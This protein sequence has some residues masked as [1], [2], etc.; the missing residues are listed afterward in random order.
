M[1]TSYKA[2]NFQFSLA[3]L[4][5]LCL[6]YS[7]IPILTTTSVPKHLHRNLLFL[8][9]GG[10]RLSFTHAQERKKN[11]GVYVLMFVFVC[12]QREDRRV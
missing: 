2:P 5:S 10:G 9:G 8:G 4:L 12:R 6:S 11:F 7:P 1:I 3:S